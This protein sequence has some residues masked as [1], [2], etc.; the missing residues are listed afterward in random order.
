MFFHFLHSILQNFDF[1][2]DAIRDYIELLQLYYDVQSSD[3]VHQFFPL[4]L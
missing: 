2:A 3:S 1:W 4:N